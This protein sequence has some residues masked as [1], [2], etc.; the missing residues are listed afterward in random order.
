MHQCTCPFLIGDLAYAEAAEA[1]KRH[2]AV[3]PLRNIKLVNGLVFLERSSDPDAKCFF[4][5]HYT[6]L[7]ILS[8]YDGLNHWYPEFLRN[9]CPGIVITEVQDVPNRFRYNADAVTGMWIQMISIAVL[10]I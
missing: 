7:L 6:S 2:I 9:N 5:D 8:F 3:T 1:I 4:C 10:T